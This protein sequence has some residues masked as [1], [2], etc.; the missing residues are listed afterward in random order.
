M[1]IRFYGLK[2]MVRFCIKWWR[3]NVPRK[4]FLNSRFAQAI[5]DNKKTICAG[6]IIIE[7]AKAQLQYRRKVYEY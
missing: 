2:N 6:E 1:I 7:C 5:L 3:K 4:K